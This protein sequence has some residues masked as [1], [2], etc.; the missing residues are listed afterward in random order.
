MCQVAYARACVR[1]QLPPLAADSAW[2][3]RVAYAR[4]CMGGWNGVYGRVKGSGSAAIRMS[5]HAWPVETALV[6]GRHR[7]ILR[8]VYVGACV[9]G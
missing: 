1:G 6:V 5:G 4:A 8:L 3:W 9:G 2:F 7:W